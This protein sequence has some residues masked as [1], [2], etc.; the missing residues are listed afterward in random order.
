MAR[1]A[2]ALDVEMMEHIGAFLGAKRNRAAA[3]GKPAPVSDADRLRS[4]GIKVT[5]K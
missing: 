4:I 5:K 1:Q 3:V 2:V